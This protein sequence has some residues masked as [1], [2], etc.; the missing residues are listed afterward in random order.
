M[1]NTHRQR[2][3]GIRTKGKKMAQTDN[4]KTNADAM[5]PLLATAAL[6]G[7]DPA[8]AALLKELVEDQL[9]KRR[10]EK[11]KAIRLAESSVQSAKEE[12]EMREQ[13]QKRCSHRKQDDSTRLCGQYLSGTGQ[14]TLVCTYCGKNYFAPPRAGQ[15][16][17]PRE[18]VPSPDVIGG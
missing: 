3:V 13:Q 12:K 16:A 9:D 7:G 10:K 8:L 18:L 1:E 2:T 14:L 6:G 5:L 4:K 11:D 17:P 15:E